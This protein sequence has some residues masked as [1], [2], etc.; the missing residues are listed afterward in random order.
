MHD[1]YLPAIGS[2]VISKLNRLEVDRE[3]QVLK[4]MDRYRDS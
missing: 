1:K 3:G 4:N 2:R